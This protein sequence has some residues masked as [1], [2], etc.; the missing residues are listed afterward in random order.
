MEQTGR[1]ELVLSPKGNLELLEDSGLLRDGLPMGP[2]LVQPQTLPV[3]SLG[4]REHFGS[5]DAPK[6]DCTPL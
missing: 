1:P 4:D 3:C 6:P 5:L 2:G